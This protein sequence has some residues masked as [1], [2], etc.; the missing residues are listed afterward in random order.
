MSRGTLNKMLEDKKL[1]I[2]KNEVGNRV[3]LLTQDVVRIKQ[4]V[5]QLDTIKSEMVR[6][7]EKMGLY[8]ISVKN[9]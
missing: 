4:N 1:V 3:Y 5:L 7:A 9:R 6:E 2:R 8:D